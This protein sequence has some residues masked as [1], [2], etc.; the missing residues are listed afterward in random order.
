MT[1]LKM[2]DK[3]VDYRRLYEAHLGRML[4][5]DVHVHHIDH[6][7]LNNCPSN[8]VAIPAK[9]HGQYH[10]WHRTY[11]STL[12]NGVPP[13]KPPKALCAKYSFDRLYTKWYFDLSWEQQQDYVDKCQDVLAQ[14]RHYNSFLAEKKRYSACLKKIKS[15][16]KSQR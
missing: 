2:R 15:I 6:N 10:F 14:A 11:E 4:P 7:R 1:Y 16:K 9:L 8:L 12:S 5:K 3:P 13:M